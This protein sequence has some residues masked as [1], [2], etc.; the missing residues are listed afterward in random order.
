[1]THTS[2]KGRVVLVT[3]GS[4]GLGREM[5][6]ALA[7]AGS[8]VVITGAA[9]SS[10]LEETQ[11]LLGVETLAV[12]A[13][14]ANPDAAIR[15][16]EETISNFGRLDV[17]INNA[18]LGM[19]RISETFNTVTTRFWESTPDSWSEIVDVNINGPFLMARS[20]IP[21]M[22]SQGFGKIINISTSDQTM[23]RR[24]Y[25][26]YGPTKAFLEAASR[27]WA[28]EL[29]DTGI[30]VNVLLPGGATDT[31]L[32]PPSPN[33]KGADGNLLSPTIMRAPILWLASDLSNGVTGGRFIARLWDDE[34][35]GKARD[36][37]GEKPQ[38]M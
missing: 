3:G 33:K 25:S 34:E 24:G 6:M 2:L 11:E 30:D 26:P 1:M 14:V 29:K 15:V 10:A 19:R 4:R 7:E 12:A 16:V 37:S 27:A 8:K 21:Q 23:I 35:P 13:D 20:T 28:E 18:G 31:D 5:A 22:L 38:I 9:P 36:D 32:L 17:L